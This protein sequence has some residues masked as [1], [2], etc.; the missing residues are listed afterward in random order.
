MTG[1]ER[2]QTASVIKAANAGLEGTSAPTCLPLRSKARKKAVPSESTPG[3][4]PLSLV[5]TRR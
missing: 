5:I 1:A 2:S 3:F 4:G